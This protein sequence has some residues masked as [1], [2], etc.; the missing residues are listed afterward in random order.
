M[1]NKEPKYLDCFSDANL[2]SKNIMYNY[3]NLKRIRSRVRT[4]N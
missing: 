1:I 2:K 3:N 4:G